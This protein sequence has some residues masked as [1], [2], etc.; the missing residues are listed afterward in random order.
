MP[1]ISSMKTLFH[2]GVLIISFL[3]IF[4]WNQ[5]GPTDYTIQL[6]AGLV[7]IYGMLLFIRRKRNK[8][9]NG[10]ME[11]VLD[12][13]LLNT[14]IFL[15]LS[16]TGKIYS[17]VFFL[18]YFLGFGIAFIFEPFTVFLFA[19]GAI[20]ILL[21]QALTNNSLESYIRLG[22]LVLISPL[23]YFFGQE[24]KDRDKEE[25]AMQQLEERAKD[26]ADTISKDVEEVLHKEKQV[27]KPEEVEKLDEILE[28]TEDLRQETED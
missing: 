25:E 17:P 27:L 20:A 28:E 14:A 16:I 10:A 15:M 4:I 11:G 2:F 1:T 24:Y 26:S 23:A 8:E 6:L 9:P 19:L 3:V 21:P 13:F 18:L 22:S 7:V 5:I 12:L